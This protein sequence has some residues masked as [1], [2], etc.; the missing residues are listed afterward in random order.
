[1]FS[2]KLIYGPRAVTLLRF[3]KILDLKI[4]IVTQY[5][6]NILYCFNF[7]YY[8]QVSVICIQEQNIHN[9]HFMVKLGKKKL[10]LSSSS[11]KAIPVS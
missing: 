7:P 2:C 3:Y 1:M 9:N 6:L 5:Y 4:K 11:F 8:S 10:L